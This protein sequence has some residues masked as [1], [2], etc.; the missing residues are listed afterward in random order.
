MNADNN[1]QPPSTGPGIDD[2]LYLL[3]AHKWRIILATLVSAGAAAAWFFLAPVPWQSQARFM[4]R[5]LIDKNVVDGVEN[6]SAA[7]SVDS[8][9]ILEAQVEILTSREIA[10]EVVNRIGAERILPEAR[11]GEGVE[12]AVS[13]I[14]NNLQVGA[15]GG[16][17][18]ISARFRH[19]DPEVARLVLDELLIQY[20]KKHLEIYRP[21]ESVEIVRQKIEKSAEAL[22][23]AIAESQTLKDQ[24]GILS[25]EQ[26]EMTL[27]TEISVKKAAVDAAETELIERR[28]R[29]AAYRNGGTPLPLASAPAD[30]GTAQTRSVTPPAE[31]TTRYQFL[32]ARI[33]QLTEE[34]LRLTAQFNPTHP[35][36]V[37]NARKVADL[38]RE[39]QTLE[40]SFPALIGTAETAG[41]AQPAFNL[42]VELA[43]IAACEAKVEALRASLA[44]LEEKAARFRQAM[45]LLAEA[46]RTREIEESNYKYMGTSLEKAETDAAMNP[47]N[48]PYINFFEPATPPVPDAGKRNRIALAIAGSGPALASGLV[49]LS[50]LFLNRTIRRPREFERRVGLPLMLSIP[51]CDSRRRPAL[52]GGPSAMPALREANG[53]G[54]TSADEPWTDDHFIRP[55]AE[56]IKD[57]VNLFF[58][59]NRIVRVPKLIAVTGISRGAGASTLAAGLAAALSR[60]GD[61]KVL[62]VDM[63]IEHG[64]SHPF[65]AGRPSS[66]LSHALEASRDLKP[67]ADNLFLAVSDSGDH[68]TLST[69][70]Q[71]LARMI[72][73]IKMG[74]FDYVIFDMPPLT[75]TS[76]TAVVS[77]LMDKVLVVVA[78]ETGTPE[79]IQRGYRDLTAARANTSFIFNQARSYGPEALLGSN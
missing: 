54:R 49:L 55:Y 4:V 79:D 59:M 45:P 43:E 1:T 51:Y 7:N 36:V 23:N 75:Q 44:E 11:R 24:L 70:V 6:A 5:Y 41:G 64:A 21:A 19:Q 12:G 50:G 18:I 9:R 15:S 65:F 56:A 31:V 26:A 76:P 14:Q 29:V 3:F 46:E 77:G 40:A 35:V 25:V 63:N 16:A 22:R 10:R 72:P 38:E 32:A 57:R 62:M 60:D 68:R 42:E 67:A 53:S 58:E 8:G 33:T 69:S 20:A 52:S 78:P 28:A 2:I 27:T 74:E 73:D 39:K 48:I 13:F 47:G 66:G 71:K 17:N 34:G 37:A 30:S 61:G